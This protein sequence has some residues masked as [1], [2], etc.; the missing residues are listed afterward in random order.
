M[1]ECKKG[2]YTYDCSKP[3]ES[4]CVTDDCGF[5]EG[6]CVACDWVPKGQACYDGGK[7]CSF[8]YKPVYVAQAAF[9]L[10]WCQKQ[11][12]E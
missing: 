7:C 9:Y 5:V 3:C 2:F 12:Y 8:S 6:Y 1:Y 10:T 4:T 11:C